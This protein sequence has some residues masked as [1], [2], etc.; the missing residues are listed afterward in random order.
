MNRVSLF[1]KIA[2]LD[3]LNA[4]LVVAATRAYVMKSYTW[5]GV[6]EVVF[7]TQWFKSRNISFDDVESRK[8]S[9]GYPAYL[10]GSV[11]GTLVGLWLSIHTLGE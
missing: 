8:W 3:F 9:F 4:V 2:A 10:L 1:L 7:V 11:T 6:I 5:T